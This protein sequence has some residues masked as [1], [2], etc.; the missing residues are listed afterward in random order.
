MSKERTFRKESGANCLDHQNSRSKRT[1]PPMLRH[2]TQSSHLL[3]GHPRQ[4]HSAVLP[5]HRR[6]LGRNTRQVKEDSQTRSNPHQCKRRTHNQV[7]SLVDSLWPTPRRR[8]LLGLLKPSRKVLLCC[9]H[10]KMIE[11][12]STS[13]TLVQSRV[14][15]HE[16]I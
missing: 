13:T 4:Q 14:N 15:T 9:Q 6:V 11:R 16:E 2:G 1:P 8:L 12:V 7:V 10:L 3:R 5:H